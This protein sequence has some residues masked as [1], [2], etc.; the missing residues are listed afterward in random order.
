MSSLRR[1]LVSL[2]FGLA[3]AG[4]TDN[5]FEDGD[6]LATLC[7]YVGELAVRL[8]EAAVNEQ[9]YP[10]ERLARLRQ[11]DAVLRD[12]VTSRVGVATLREVRPHGGS[13]TQELR[14]QDCLFLLA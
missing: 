13:A 9:L 4:V 3:L 7:M 14:R 10:V 12:V 5:L 6:Y 8:D 1:F 2:L 11:R